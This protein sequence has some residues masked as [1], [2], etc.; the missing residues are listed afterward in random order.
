MRVPGTEKALAEEVSGNRE[1]V[2]AT[3]RSYLAAARDIPSEREQIPD[4]LRRLK[5][6][7]YG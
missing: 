7:E 3:W 6:L 1:R 4:V 2:I 5:I